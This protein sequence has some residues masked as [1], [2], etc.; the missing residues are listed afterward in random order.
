MKPIKIFGLVVLAALMA[1]ALLGVSLASAE[2]TGLCETDESPCESGNEVVHIHLVTL[3]GSK[4]KLLSSVLSVECD[5]LFL[6]PA[7]L[8]LFGNIKIHILGT[9]SNCNNSCTLTEENGPAE[10]EILREGTELVKVTGGGLVHLVC[11][12]FI[13]CRYN[14]VGLLGH[15]LGPLT[16]SETNGSANL[17]EQTLNKESGTFCP[18]TTKLD[19][20]TTPLEATY[21]SG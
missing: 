14:G 5:S 1:M 11:S 10:V 16:S 3:S 18:S 8:T 20:T 7:L 12:G 13:N 21:I 19:I 17:S 15:G 2:H 4:A 6:G 9:Y